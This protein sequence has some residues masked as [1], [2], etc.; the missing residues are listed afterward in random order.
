[1]KAVILAGGMGTRLGGITKT[2]PKPMVGIDGKPLLERM[3]LHLKRHG[4]TDIVICT[5]HLADRIRAHFGDGAAF[6]VRI[7]YSQESEPLGTG[8]A[9]KNAAPLLDGPFLL[10]LGDLV[11]GMDLERL[12]AFHREKKALGT[13][14]V[15]RSSH[16]HDSDIIEVAPDGSI[17]RF[18]GKPKP[19]QRFTNIANAGVYC[20]EHSILNYFPDGKSMLDKEV[21]PSVLE[22]GGRLFAYMTDEEVSDIGTAER[23]SRYTV[24]R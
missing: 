2:I 7:E 8:G 5:Y 11:V 9:L 16:P 17:T 19:S 3:I 1:M 4:F 18:L 21:L 22:R 20:F 15:H 13:L 12:V 24:K 14:T 23:L 6:G 10:L